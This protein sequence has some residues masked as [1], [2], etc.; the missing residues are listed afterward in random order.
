MEAR[1][2]A[3]LSSCIPANL[4]DRKSVIDSTWLANK[5]MSDSSVKIRTTDADFCGTE[6]L[7]ML[8]RTIASILIVLA[9]IAGLLAV[10]CGPDPDP[11]PATPASTQADSTAVAVQPATMVDASTPEAT[12]KTESAE[13]STPSP[14]PQPVARAQSVPDPAPTTAPTQA[15]AAPSPTAEPKPQAVPEPTATEPPKPGESQMAVE[16][17]AGTKLPGAAK[18][19]LVPAVSLPT[20]EVVQLLTPSVVNI[21]TELASTG[22]FNTPFPPNGSATGVILSPEGHVLT[23]NHVVETGQS[24]T[25]TLN[26]GSNHEA[27]VVGQ[28]P[29]T[30]L[31]VIKIGDVEGLEPARLGDSSTLMVGEDVI[32]IGHAM[33]LP[34]A[35]TVSKGVVSALER[36]IDTT[37]NTTIVDLIQTDASINPGNSGGPLVNSRAEVIG[38]NTIV[39]SVGQGIGFAININDAKEVAR[40]IIDQGFVRRGYL[41]VLPAAITPQVAAY[42][43]ID[44]DVEGIFLR[45]VL[46]GSVSDDAGLKPGDIILSMDDQTLRNT[47]ELSKFLISHQPGDTMNITLLRDGDELIASITLGE[48]SGE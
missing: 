26:D 7:T 8:K 28:D 4:I 20:T 13:T 25:V 21:T 23:N 39:V 24:I 33:G 9:V 44:S 1:S 11:Q 2:I 10:A 37:H 12:A 35:P 14:D 42:L 19:S 46:P 27:E 34:G 29:V 15:E 17:S 30:D 3:L 48:R 43:G 32:A 47:G 45:Q 41:G 40:Q 6:V 22:L 31:A 16:G 5:A 36:S 38:I 18:V